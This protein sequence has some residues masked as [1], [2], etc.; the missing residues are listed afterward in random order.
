MTADP[1]RLADFSHA[2]LELAERKTSSAEILLAD[3]AWGFPRFTFQRISEGRSQASAVHV[4]LTAED[5]LTEVGRLVALGATAGATH[6]DDEFRWTVMRD[7][8]GNELC[9]TD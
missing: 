5:R 4:D 3:A 6:G 2:A 1:D 8:D 7:P 9:V